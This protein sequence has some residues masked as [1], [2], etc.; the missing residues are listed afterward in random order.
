V[1]DKHLEQTVERIRR[2]SPILWGMINNEKIG[3]VGAM[4]D[5]HNGKVTFM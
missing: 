4:Y 5:V 3:L 1:T 2:R